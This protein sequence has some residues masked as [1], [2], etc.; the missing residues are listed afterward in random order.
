M[1]GGRAERRLRAALEAGATATAF[2][3]GVR[4]PGG[5][6]VDLEAVE[7]SDGFGEWLGREPHSVVGKRYSEL[8]PTGLH[9]RLAVYLDAIDQ[10]KAAQLIFERPGPDGR[11]VT[12]EVRV[13]PCGDDEIFAAVWDVTERE[14]RLQAARDA[15]EAARQHRADLERALDALPMGI[16]IVTGH[17]DD[18]GSV[19]RATVD[20][21]NL[22]GASWTHQPAGDWVGRDVMEALPG[23][24]RL[25]LWDAFVEC[26]DEVEHVVR[27]F[28][29][30][31]EDEWSGTFLASLA[32]FQADRAILVLQELT[33]DDTGP[34]SSAVR[35]DPLTGLLTRKA[36][37]HQL[38]Q[39]LAGSIGRVDVGL[40]VAIDVDDFGRLNDVVGRHRADE[41]LLLLAEGLRE[42]QP[43]LELISRTGADG[44]AFV[45]PA[46][47]TGERIETHQVQMGSLIRRISSSLGVPSVS[48]SGGYRIL[49]PAV[50][51]DDLLQD[52]D[53]ALRASVVEGG[54]RLTAFE[55]V[56]RQRMHVTYHAGEDIRG[57][58][59]R[60]EFVL[61]YQPIVRVEDGEPI[62]AEALVRWR[63]PTLGLVPP[64]DFIAVA[65][66]N[67]SILVLGSWVLD[68]ALDDLSTVPGDSVVSI[69]VSGVQLLDADVPAAIAS[70]L[71]RTRVSP[72]RVIVEI[73]ESAIVPDSRRIRDQL[74]M[75]QQMGV[76]VAVDDFGSGYS[77]IAYL[78]RIPVDLVKLDRYFLDGTLD[79]RRRNVVA[80]A[81][82][83]IRS[84]G[85]RSLAEGV[86]TRE[87][88]DV[89]MEAG[90]DLAQ[91]FLF[92]RAEPWPTADA[93]PGGP[94][95]AG[96]LS[97]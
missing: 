57:A 10:N 28:T 23:V 44:F 92:G 38:A 39:R 54:G 75:I 26:L 91:G 2:W 24:R 14:Q 13:A 70:A 29:F 43:P 50:P 60:R 8:V 95:S 56:V 20:F 68:R 64:S 97:T 41:F 18:H 87:Q 32:P 69:N 5:E 3:R 55:P 11:L 81:A 22:V 16:A 53:T 7:C 6:L 37:H 12:A 30:G 78:D 48:I 1:D 74:A 85:A 76:R 4:A 86:E 73:T 35:I 45:M 90:I 33:P 21:M 63:H 61:E 40:L 65:E 79:R 89:V 77:S 88:W 25:G 9:N 67:G 83:L 58:V 15:S 66:A 19:D 36:L 80:A 27:T 49:D 84:I 31:P 93:L 46:P 62:G 52:A 72:S 59:G 42:M 47:V 96:P 82:Q 34:N 71:E 94:L 17:R 51:L